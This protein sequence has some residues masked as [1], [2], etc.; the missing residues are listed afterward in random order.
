MVQRESELTM[1][2]N[3]ANF[4]LL[5]KKFH[6]RLKKKLSCSAFANILQFIENESR[7]NPKNEPD[8]RFSLF[9]SVKGYLIDR[10]DRVT[11]YITILVIA[12]RVFRTT[13]PIP[14]FRH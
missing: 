14:S 12:C 9:L 8:K 4:S 5:V 1:Y 7:K 10:I 6:N 2:F 13:F 3:K 11:I